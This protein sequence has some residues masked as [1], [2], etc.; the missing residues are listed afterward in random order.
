M[1]E[2]ID[3]SLEAAAAKLYRAQRYVRGEYVGPCCWHLGPLEPDHYCS[4][5][6]SRMVA[7]TVLW[8]LSGWV[9]QN[10]EGYYA[11]DKEWEAMIKEEVSSE[12][13][14][15]AQAPPCDKW[16]L[17]GREYPAESWLRV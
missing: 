6:W 8:F 15:K 16:V 17:A 10:A 12:N 4:M 7:A 9:E 13:L 11:K 2:I 5:C 1:G 3:K 14:M